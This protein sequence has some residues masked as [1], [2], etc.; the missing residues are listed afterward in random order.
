MKTHRRDFIKKGIAGATAVTFGG[1]LPGFSARSYGKILGANE[2]IRTGIMGVN[3]RGLQLAGSFSKQS[4]CEII[5][6]CDVDTRAAA[7]CIDT[8]GKLQNSTP[9]AAPDF[10]KAL[11]DKQLDV[12]VIA[13]PDHWHVPA[14]M[15]ASKAGKHIYLE[16]P[17]SHNPNEG[18]MLVAAAAKYKNVIQM[19]NQRR[20]FPNIIAAIDELHN[21]AIGRVY[22]AK[23]WY[24][25]SRGSIGKG[26]E[27]PVPSWLDYDLWQGPAPRKPYKDNLIHYNWH[28]F[29][30]WGTG[31]S[32]N[33]GTHFVDLAR[34]GLGVDYPV[35]VSSSG[36][37]YHYQ[38]DWETPDTQIITMEFDNNTSMVWEG[39]S[40]NGYPTE[41]KSVGV[42]FYG[43]NGTL[44]INENSYKIFGKDNK[45]I[46]DVTNQTVVDASNK[47]NPSPGLDVVHIRNFFDSIKNGTRL[48]A[49]ILSGHKSTLLVQL[50]NISLRS[51]NT[52]HLDPASGHIKNDPAA[53]K[54]WSREYQKGWEPEI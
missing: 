26:K 46:K 12:L 41:G 51:G 2:R 7:K 21:G 3:S 34:W 16:K 52:L 28:W 14:A 13:A 39:L 23:T 44:A 35:R 32:L 24:N 19:G 49:D 17:C 43:E 4:D 33:N 36:G 48:N 9:R 22:F 1:I 30:H 31:E 37:R 40:C 11:E 15:L 8:V 10:R 25:A 18:E 54:Y 53:M 45:L 6:I 20:S 42:I 38:D 50:G 27:A 47:S 29:W 5:Y